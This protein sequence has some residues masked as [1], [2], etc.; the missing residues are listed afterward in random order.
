M[1]RWVWQTIATGVRQ[2]K[3]PPM[4]RG[5]DQGGHERRHRWVIEMLAVKR[6][7]AVR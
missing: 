7:A 5:E 1:S 2:V 4:C 3:Q 6:V